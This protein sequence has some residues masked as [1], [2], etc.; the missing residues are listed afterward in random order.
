[1]L[2][3]PHDTHERRV[4]HLPNFQKSNEKAQKTNEQVIFYPFYKNFQ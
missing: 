2:M 4:A 1:M 3:V